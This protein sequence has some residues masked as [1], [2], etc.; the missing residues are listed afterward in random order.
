RSV[1]ARRFG[2]RGKGVT[3]PTMTRIV[4]GRIAEGLAERRPHPGD[5]R[6]VSVAATPAGQDLMR[7]AQRRRIDALAD[8]LAGLPAADQRRIAAWAAL[9]DDVAAVVRARVTRQPAGRRGSR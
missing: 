8:E 9:L 2:G 4:D 7:A 3:R 5:R 1:H 6:A